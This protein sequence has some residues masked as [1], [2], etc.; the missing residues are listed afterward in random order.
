[1][2]PEKSE[3]EA[4]ERLREFLDGLPAGLPASESGVELRVLRKLFTPVEAELAVQLRYLPEPVG[5][6][7]ER[8]GLPEAEAAEK[9]ASMARR[10][11]ILSVGSGKNTFY[12]AAQFLLGIYE[13]QVDSIDNS[14]AGL[15]EEFTEEC[16]RP[17]ADFQRSLLRQFR[18]IPVETALDPT[19]SVASYDL[20]R[21]LVKKQKLAAVMPCICC[22]E[23]S[24]VGDDCGRIEERCLTFG[25]GARYIIETGKGRQ[26]SID[27][28]LEYVDMAERE[29]FV[30]LPSNSRDVVHVCLCCGHCCG[31]L[32]IL[33][34]NPRPADA[35]RSACR[36]RI[37]PGLCNA[38]GTCL[39]RCQTGAII[40]EEGAMRLDAARCIGCGLCV[41]TCKP[42]AASLVPKK[43][44]APVPAN[45]LEMLSGMSGDR[46][47]GFGKLK[48][49]MKVANVPLAVKGLPWLYRTGAGKWLMDRMARRDWI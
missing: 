20:A 17:N 47:L 31:V 3:E 24:L 42:R 40:E 14:F 19:T 16:V 10:G 46:G 2:E 28:A 36:A 7:A 37:D 44:G 33:K 8:W 26:I 49:V 13:Y 12:Q 6:I 27:E 11:L 34:M 23:R 5:V 41:S 35:I 15:M 29:A 22:K 21:K 32:R 48:A 39:D 18:V 1:M 38:C 4:Y 30:L 9:L 45:Y 25:I 43:G